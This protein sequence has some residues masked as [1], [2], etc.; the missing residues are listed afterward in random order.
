MH[1]RFHPDAELELNQAIDYYFPMSK[2][3]QPLLR[4]TWC[5]VN[6]AVYLQTTK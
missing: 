4:Q 3:E 5:L 2:E 6:G 1:F